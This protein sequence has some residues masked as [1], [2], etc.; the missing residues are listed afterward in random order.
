MYSR[1][2]YSLNM[3]VGTMPRFVSKNSFLL[4]FFT[5][6][7][8]SLATKYDNLCDYFCAT[9]PGNKIQKLF[10]LICRI[11]LEVEHGPYQNREEDVF[12]HYFSPKLCR[13][14]YLKNN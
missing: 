12:L 9:S 11:N 14:K 1:Y 6:L 10:H 3:K 5:I 2:L 8:V 4:L 7:S 13:N